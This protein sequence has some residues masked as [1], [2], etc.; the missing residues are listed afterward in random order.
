MERFRVRDRL[1]RRSA[2]ETLDEPPLGESPLGESPLG[3]PPLGEPP[4]GEPPLGESPLGG[5]SSAAAVPFRRRCA[6]TIGVESSDPAVALR[7]ALDN[8]RA[9][10]VDAAE[11]GYRA[12]LEFHPEHPAALHLLGVLVGSRDPAAGIDL[13]ERAIAAAPADAGSQLA[14]VYN[15]LGNLLRETDRPADAVAA[16]GRAT[17]L[18]PDYA[19]AF[20]NLS[21]ALGE[22]GRTAD[23]VA[24]GRRA[25]ALAPGVAAFHSHLGVALMAVRDNAGAVAALDE[26]V[27]LAPEDAGVRNN[28]GLA[29]LAAGDAAA[30]SAAFDRAVELAPD[31]PAAHNNRGTALRSLGRLDEAAN[32]FRRAIALDPE[33]AD[34]HNNLGNVLADQG[35]FQSSV[36]EATIAAKARPND[37]ATQAN[38]AQSLQETGQRDEA[39]AVALRAAALAPDDPAVQGALGIALAGLGRFDAA[40]LAYRRALELS[41]EFVA[42]HNNLGVALAAVGDEKG[43]VAA[44]RRAVALRPAL[45]ATHNNL[46]LLLLTLG[47]YPEGFR[48]HEWRYRDD[49]KYAPRQFDTPMWDGSAAN[50]GETILL[51]AEQGFGD[52]I[53]FARFATVVADRGWDVVLECSPE[54]VGL[55]GSIRGVARVVAKGQPAGPI[56][57]HCPIMSLPLVC[58]TTLE[59][60]PAPVPYVS[61][62]PAAVQQWISR[63]S[64]RGPGRRVGVVFA[65]NIGHSN[66]HNRSMPAHFLPRINLP[67]VQFVSLQK[68]S[69]A[70]IPE[71]WFDPMAGLNDYADTATLVSALDAVLAV[72]TSVAHLAGALGKPTVVMIPFVPDWRWG[73]TGSRTPWYPNT[74][75]VRQRRPGDWAGVLDAA[76][77]EL[78]EL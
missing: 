18:R 16:Y 74:R 37:A 14:G 46:S 66:D 5:M 12:V 11:R 29:L 28:L 62:D 1:S 36:K 35:L 69:P 41:P 53:Q 7:V 34:A 49:P 26:A 55:F 73:L 57:S 64:N 3:E 65:G 52:Q 48:E 45:P 67:A 58:G 21:V 8:H 59:T 72:D 24:A 31:S 10:R 39:L 71:G 75:I 44:A 25:V 23:A 38:L 4:L 76:L 60:V 47:R 78:A 42:A 2:R 30:A 17:E 9:G 50:D 13:I 6:Y 56:V 61:A 33:A 15:N 54:L 63:L 40:I 27:C 43:A 70:V 77:R 32:A 20:S 22:I 19:G 51:H 68:P